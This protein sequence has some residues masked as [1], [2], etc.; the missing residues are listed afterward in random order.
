MLSGSWPT[1]AVPSRAPAWRAW[2][3]AR[4]Q[5]H[6]AG[7]CAVEGEQPERHEATLVETPEAAEAVASYL[8]SLQ[9]RSPSSAWPFPRDAPPGQIR[10]HLGEIAVFEL[11]P[12]P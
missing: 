4:I 5:S 6:A 11:T 8:N 10:P 7:W 2:G 12:V 3:S 9:R 1:R